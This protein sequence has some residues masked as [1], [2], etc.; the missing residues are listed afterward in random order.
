MTDRRQFEASALDAVTDVV[1]AARSGLEKQDLQLGD[2]EISSKGSGES[3]RSEI[4]VYVYRDEQV[5]D[6]LEVR[7]WRDSQ[8]LV[9]V[10]ELKAWFADQLAALD[11]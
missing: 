8:P 5:C 4:R 10:D 11:V 1:N 6:A 7:L 2:V 3:Y 9:D